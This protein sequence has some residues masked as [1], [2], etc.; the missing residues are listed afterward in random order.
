MF[1]PGI[2][3]NT[4]LSRASQPSLSEF[5]LAMRN[6]PR[7]PCRGTASLEVF[8]GI[9]VCKRCGF[10]KEV[11]VFADVPS[12]QE[13]EWE[14]KQIRK[15][16]VELDSTAYYAN[17]VQSHKIASLQHKVNVL[18]DKPQ[19][20]LQRRLAAAR[21]VIKTRFHNRYRISEL[22]ITQ[23]L[24]LLTILIQNHDKRINNL[25][26]ATCACVILA[27]ERNPN[28][29]PP[30]VSSAI[31]RLGVDAEA[32]NLDNS[33]RSFLTLAR[34]VL[35]M[36]A[37]S[38]EH[39]VKQWCVVFENDIDNGKLCKAYRERIATQLKLTLL[40]IRR[41]PDL[42]NKT[43]L[44]VAAAVVYMALNNLNVMHNTV[45]AKVN[46]NWIRRLTNASYS[47]LKSVV[48]Q[49]DAI[50]FVLH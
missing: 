35:K 25:A 1:R 21:S 7:V 4:L 18:N 45:E 14:E 50:P 40:D 6:C 32:I 43:P 44:T 9:C 28:E 30:S 15:N 42:K 49:C 19:S 3:I 39:S 24:N 29:C 22:L 10:Q 38:F 8:D 47:G 13:D 17:Q 31:C 26:S 36:P 34:N 5:N 23:A 11:D 33:V 2:S 41:K 37:P 46:K 48:S 27:A 12:F 16:R 20:D